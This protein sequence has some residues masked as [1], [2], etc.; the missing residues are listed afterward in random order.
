MRNLSI[1]T[2]PGFPWVSWK[3]ASDVKSTEVGDV[4]LD[5]LTVMTRTS[6][7]GSSAVLGSSGRTEVVKTKLPMWLIATSVS[8][9][10]G[11][12]SNGMVGTLVALLTVALSA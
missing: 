3:A 7:F 12:S 10:S 5:E 11:V 6:E 2:A 8:M 1:F 9:P 4:W